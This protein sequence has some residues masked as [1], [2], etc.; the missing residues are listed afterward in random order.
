MDAVF[1]RTG[2]V[3]DYTPPSTAV[4]AGDVLV[5]GDTVAVAKT[6]LAVGE[7]GVLSIAGAFRV[8]KATT[9]ASAIAAG[10][11]VYWNAGSDVATE[12][13]GSNKVLGYTLEA[14]AA[15]DDSVLVNLAR[16]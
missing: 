15:T 5:I 11:K 4:E 16:A 12:T 14:A 9:S 6:N 3:I 8:P 2:D 10:K 13:S 1:V 7:K